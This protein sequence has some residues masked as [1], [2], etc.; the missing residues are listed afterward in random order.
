[1]RRDG[2]MRP[3]DAAKDL[4]CGKRWLL[5]GLNIHGFPHT[6]MG[7]AKW[8]SPE[9]REAIRD[10]CKVPGSPEKMAQFRRASRRVVRVKRRRT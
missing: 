9:D 8:L 10:L 3:A 4:G 6:R 2:Y 7:K 1:M 5:D